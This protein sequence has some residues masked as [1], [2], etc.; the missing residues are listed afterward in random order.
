MEFTAT[1]TVAMIKLTGIPVYREGLV[2]YLPSGSWSVV[3][4]CSGVRYLIA[5]VTLGCL[6]AYLNYQ[7]LLKRFLFIV[8]AIIVPILANG[9]RAYIIVM[10]GHLSD[11]TMATG[12]DHL[13][14]GWVFF[15]FVMFILFSVGS[16]WRDHE[17]SEPHSP[18]D[19]S[20]SDKDRKSNGLPDLLVAAG[21]ILGLTAIWPLFALAME[22]RPVPIAGEKLQPPSGAVG[23]QRGES[24]QWA[25]QPLSIGASQEVH[26]FYEKDGHSVGL[27]LAYYPVQRQGEELINSQNSLLGTESRSWRITSR[28]VLK[29]TINDE[30][31]EVQ[32]AHIKGPEI[33]LLVWSWYR[34]GERHTSNR[35]VAKILD[36]FA[37]LTFSRQDATWLVVV[38]QVTDT[39]QDETEISAGESLRQFVEDLMPQITDQIDRL[40]DFSNG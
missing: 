37:K 6:F 8:A 19:Y 39:P 23:W 4:A 26:Q 24:E 25:L 13:I 29:T 20:E 35:Y 32:Q 31:F 14:Y 9:L 22:H 3:D 5:S 27:Y 7:S 12:V 15:G 2:F 30:E 11:M 34:L 17:K 21:I 36:A 18:P 38:T 10:I 28:R 33:S 40:A 1:F 16:I